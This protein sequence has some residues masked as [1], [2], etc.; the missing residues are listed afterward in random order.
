[1]AQYVTNGACGRMM[2]CASPS[3]SPGRTFG[4]P[5]RSCDSPAPSFGSPGRAFG[6]PGHSSSSP[7]RSFGNRADFRTHGTYQSRGNWRSGKT[8]STGVRATL[9]ADHFATLGVRHNASK[10]EIKSAYRKLAKQFHPDVSRESDQSKFIQ[11]NNAYESALNC[12]TGSN[13]ASSN[14]DADNYA[15]DCREELEDWEDYMGFEGAGNVYYSV[16]FPCA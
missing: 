16:D 14:C 3:R 8:T 4:S 6:S 5:T 2:K 13:Y 11:I 9:M 12:V 10:T 7:T 15:E 1:M